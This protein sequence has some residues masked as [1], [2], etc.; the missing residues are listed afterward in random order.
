EWLIETE[1]VTQAQT[2]TLGDRVLRAE[3]LVDDIA[4][5]QAQQEEDEDCNPQQRWDNRQ[6]ALQ[7]VGLHAAPSGEGPPWAADNWNA[8]AGIGLRL[9]SCLVAVEG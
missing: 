8:Y 3:H 2:L 5:N 6:R 7:D 9:P 1:E 4:R